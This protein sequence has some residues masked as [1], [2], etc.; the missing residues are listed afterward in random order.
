MIRS[1][2]DDQRIVITGVGLTAPNGDTLS[3]YRTALLEGRSGVGKYHIRY[4]GDTLAGECHFD[5]LRYQKRKEVRRGTRAGSVGI[6]CANE[7]IADSGIEWAEVDPTRV[8][9][10]VGVTEHGKRGRQRTRSMRSR[11][12]TTTRKYGHTTTILAP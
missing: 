7:A 11:L 10:Y 8:G 4:V 6:Y 12:S 1:A 2:L 5:E 3:D 9:V